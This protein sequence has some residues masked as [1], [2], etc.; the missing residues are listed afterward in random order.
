M[1]TVSFP[2]KEKHKGCLLH[3]DSEGDQVGNLPKRPEQS[4]ARLNQPSFEIRDDSG[5]NSAY[6]FLS[7]LYRLRPMESLRESQ[8]KKEIS[9]LHKQLTIVRQATQKTTTVIQGNREAWHNYITN[10]KHK[11]K[12]RVTKKIEQ[13]RKK[14]ILLLPASLV[15]LLQSTGGA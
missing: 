12:N 9:Q 6:L 1:L 4:Q 15:L 2:H 3:T 7:G 11:P 10:H 13:K 8:K 5:A 14:G